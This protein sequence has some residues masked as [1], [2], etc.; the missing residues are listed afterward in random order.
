MG[1]SKGTPF[2]PCSFAL[3]SFVIPL[4]H[5]LKS[6]VGYKSK[7]IGGCVTHLLFMDDL[8]VYARD[9][10]AMKKALF[11]VDRV[12]KAVG[13]ELGLQKCAV[14]NILKGK[15]QEGGALALSEDR[16]VRATS[17][18]DPYRYLGMEQVI[19][20]DL[21]AVKKKLT[22]R[23]MKRLRMIWSSDLDSKYK[24]QAT[25]V[26][27]VSNFRYYFGTLK[28]TKT[29]LTLLDRANRCV[30]RKNKCHQ[31]SVAPERMYLPR[32][33]GGRGLHNLLHLREREVVS[34]ALYLAVPEDP[35]LRAVARHQL[36]MDK[37]GSY[38]VLTVANG[39]LSHYQLGMMFTEEG[40]FGS[41]G[42]AVSRRHVMHL[43]K[44]V[45]YDELAV[46][47]ERKTIHRVFFKQCQEEG[48]NTSGS[49]AW[50]LDGR[51]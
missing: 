29:D 32:S 11:L 42:K 3:A 17:K 20:L 15:L 30:M 24:A 44:K 12:S 47:L 50:L 46:C 41:D 34:T 40:L 26:W 51:V 36:S 18:G 37:R 4:S 6:V 28:W 45:P 33:R 48:W 27:E 21:K 39:V 9:E 16:T 49:H 35:L 23:Y 13:M 31:Y 10:R 1:Y 22:E 14:A 38:C 19:E 43:L 8:K 7:S 2:H 5:T 25:N